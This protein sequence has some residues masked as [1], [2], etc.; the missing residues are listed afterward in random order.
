[1]IRVVMRW[2]QGMCTD[3]L[4]FTL[5][6]R[7]TPKTSARRSLMKAVQPVIA[8]NGIPYL[9]MRLLGSKK[10]RMG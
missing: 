6:L 3:L 8:S 9:Q 2:Y 7:E 4:T 10:E 1:M 5:Q